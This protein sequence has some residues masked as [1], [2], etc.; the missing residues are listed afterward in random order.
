M[1]NRAPLNK[2]V[3][4]IDGWLNN[5]LSFKLS[6]GL[7]WIIIGY[8]IVKFP[9]W[10]LKVIHRKAFPNALDHMCMVCAT[11]WMQRSDALKY[12]SELSKN[13]QPLLKNIF[14]VFWSICDW[15]IASRKHEIAASIVLWKGSI[16]NALGC[17]T[18]HIQVP[19][20]PQKEKGL[21]F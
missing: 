9:R 19:E 13:F 16:M 14:L 21:F 17:K 11:N 10:K 1:F 15:V 2:F 20:S 5:V 4:E 6:K 7:H 8:S 3:F 18:H 12:T